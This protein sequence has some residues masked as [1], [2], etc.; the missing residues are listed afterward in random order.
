MQGAAIQILVALSFS[1]GVGCASSPTIS[2]DANGAWSRFRTWDWA[3]SAAQSAE[4]PNPD[5]VELNHDIARLVAHALADRGFEWDHRAPDLLVDVRLS[6]QRERVIVI[7]TGAIDQL[8]SL[9]SSPSYQV[10]TTTKR[11]ETYERSRLVVI[12][13]DT[14]RG[15]TV[16]KGALEE[17][18]R[19]QAAPHS[20]SMIETLLERFPPAGDADDGYPPSDRTPK[21]DAPTQFARADTRST[22]GGSLPD[23]VARLR[24]SLMSLPNPSHQSRADL[25]RSETSLRVWA[26]LWGLCTNEP[27]PARSL[28]RPNTATPL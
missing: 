27:Q 7:E 20:E 21:P 3:P 28:L 16:W 11:V 8:S 2:F 14:R 4:A 19:D 13:T 18:F 12:A 22:P 10:Q 25:L 17:R 24:N 9:H 5:I 6:V 26:P 23:A 1:V 15:L